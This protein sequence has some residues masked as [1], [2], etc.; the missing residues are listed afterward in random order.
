MSVSA[1]GLSL[2][3]TW[4]NFFSSD[5]Q[6][7]PVSTLFPRRF[8][9]IRVTNEEMDEIDPSKD[10]APRACA[11]APLCFIARQNRQS[12]SARRDERRERSLALE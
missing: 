5:G 1:G 7:D 6:G 3:G 2:S 4:A 11:E 8:H 10:A 12:E 9:R